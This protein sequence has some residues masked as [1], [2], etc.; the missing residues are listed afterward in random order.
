MR[1]SALSLLPLLLLVT[2]CDDYTAPSLYQATTPECKTWTEG[3]RFEL[4]RGISIYATPPV[5]LKDGGTELALIFTLPV[6]TQASFTRL[7]FLLEEP[8][9]PP[10]AAAK[11]LT[12]YQRGMNQ[13]AEIVDV[14]EQLPIMF[15]AV[16]SSK[17]TQWR[18]R[19]QLPRQ[20]PQR[21]DLSM[22]DMLVGGKRYPVRTFT[23]RYF[24]ERSAYGM[25]S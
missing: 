11:I 14:I 13:K 2:A 12:I 1:R 23:Y 22:P 20:L 18:L 24:P 16:G 19:L 4:P 10:F 17:E 9:K 25:C 5:T 6:G 15:A 7:S 21:F 8:K 3:S